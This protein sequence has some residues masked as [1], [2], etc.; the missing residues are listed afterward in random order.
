MCSM[1]G[2]LA[3]VVLNN[4][5]KHTI[6]QSKFACNMVALVD[7]TPLSL[8]LKDFLSHFLTFRQS[9]ESSLPPGCLCSEPTP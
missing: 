5:Y 9:F 6:L 2:A 8:N 4:L 7:G 1:G 3:Q